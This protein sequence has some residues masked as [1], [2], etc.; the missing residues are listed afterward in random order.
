MEKVFGIA[1][2]ITYVG[3][4]DPSLRVFDVIMRTEYGTSYNAYLVE[5]RDAVALIDTVK[6][7]YGNELKSRLSRLIDAK[8][9]SYIIANH[10]EPDH[11]GSLSCALAMMPG[12]TVVAT[13]AGSTLAKEIINA[14]FESLVA[15]EGD[16]IDLGGKTLRF[17]MAPNLHWPDTMFTYVEED[18]VLFSGDVF[19]C[20]YGQAVGYMD[21]IGGR[22]RDVAAAQRYY[23]DVIMSPF[24]KDMLQ[25]IAKIK[26]LPIDVLCPSHGPLLRG[27][28]VWPTVALSEGWSQDALHARTS[29]T[30]LIAYVSAY[31]YTAQLAERIASGVRDAGI[32]GV[33][34]ETYEITET[35]AEAIASKAAAADALLLGSPTVNRDALPPAWA[36]AT[37]LSAIAMRGKWGGAFGSYGWSGEAAAML[38]ERMRSIG[39]KIAEGMVRAKLAPSEAELEQ[40]YAYGKA[41]AARLRP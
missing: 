30:I 34:A 24:Q 2:G 27:Q 19:G 29:K 14:P 35:G 11:S 25:A 41:F 12:A 32:A 9:K 20:H 3:Q 8:K 39:M 17:I 23:F 7:R 1:D 15:K 33:A 22:I 13:R 37:A 36:V 28:D 26:G 5:G 4:A 10:T 31:G 6:S 40:A 21:E 16:A 18:R 38:Q